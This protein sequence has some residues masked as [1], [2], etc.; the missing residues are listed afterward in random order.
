M[1][2]ACWLLRFA[3]GASRRISPSKFSLTLKPGMTMR[4]L[5]SSS[6]G[7]VS[8]RMPSFIV[9]EHEPTRDDAVHLVLLLQLC[10]DPARLGL[11]QRLHSLVLE[12]NL[13]M[14][15][16]SLLELLSFLCILRPETTGSR[17]GSSSRLLLPI[18]GPHL[19][20]QQGE[21]VLL[22]D[23]RLFDVVEGSPRE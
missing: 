19:A 12:P 18:H 2:R 3:V 9:R 8:V 4:A 15:L 7:L 6:I 13:P 5:A 11:V 17:G 1:K 20:T 16:S 21:P 22:R 10:S 23:H 14:L